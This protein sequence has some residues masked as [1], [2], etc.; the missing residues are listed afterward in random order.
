MG[1]F[2]KSLI[3]YDSWE[4]HNDFEMIHPFR[5]LNGRVGRLI[6][7]SKAVKEGYNFEIPFLQMYYYQT[8]EH[9]V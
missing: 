1:F 7:L 8:L 6:W 2:I 9:S 3:G 5:D 4:S